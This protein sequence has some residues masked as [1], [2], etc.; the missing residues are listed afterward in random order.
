MKRYHLAVAALFLP[1]LAFS[2]N[3]QL[4]GR[5]ALTS[6]PALTAS[7][8]AAKGASGCAGLVPNETLLVSKKFELENAVVFLANIKPER[9]P[10][11][12][13]AMDIANCTYKPRVSALLQ[14]D[15]LVLRSNDAAIHH[16][17]AYLREFTPAWDRLVTKDLFRRDSTEVFNFVFRA[18]NSTAWEVLNTPGVLEIR[19]ET[20]EDWLKAYVFV[21]PHR[22]FAISNAKGEFAL[23]GLPPGKYD[24]VLW[25]ETLGLKR[26][27]V[28]V[29][30]N[31]KNEMLVNWEISTP[32][33]ADSLSQAQK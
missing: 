20:G 1:G 18:K 26:Q 21:M 6:M 8:N 2:Q 9:L 24:L 3:L 7:Q 15:T 27:L 33:S 25:H 5:I 14:G 28:E 31:Q 4:K 29:S 13:V 19:S 16:A 23:E 11:A 10:A 30:A 17:R 32:A 22:F 12:A